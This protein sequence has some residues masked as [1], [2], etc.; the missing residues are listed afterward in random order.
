MN[1]LIVATGTWQIVVA[2]S[3][4]RQEKTHKNISSRDYL[5]LSAPKLSEKMKQIMMQIASCTWNWQKIIWADDILH[6]SI[7]VF[8]DVKFVHSLQVFRERVSVENFAEIWLCKLTDNAEKIVAES[9]IDAAI[10][11]YEDGLHS[12]VPQEDWKLLDA[13]LIF[14]PIALKRRLSY[15]ITEAQ[16]S[17]NYLNNYC[18]CYK[19]IKR[20]NK[21]YFLIVDYLPLPRYLKYHLIKINK[22]SVINTLNTINLS[23][24]PL[25]S[26][27]S[28]TQNGFLILGQCFSKWNLMS[29]EEEFDIYS[30]IFS[31]VSQLD[32]VL[33][34]KEHPRVDRPFFNYLANKYSRIKPIELN[35]HFAWPIELFARQLNLQGCVSVTSTSL[36]YL[37]SLFEI[38]TY[39][40]ANNLLNS[41]NGDFSYMTKLVANNIPTLTSINTTEIANNTLVTNK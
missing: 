11:I 29:W 9:Y 24:N 35:V 7:P 20:I 18:L 32:L 39:T 37:K 15:R 5:V 21:A 30:Q 33:I 40:V 22:Q 12:Y 1:R 38:P 3:A 6:S 14:K 17:L 8:T 2:T 41:F 26:I 16:T 25:K 19:H 23:I 36:F 27:D 4:L 13:N 28:K 31:L 34:W 10:A